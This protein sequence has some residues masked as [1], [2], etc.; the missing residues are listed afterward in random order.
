MDISNGIPYKIT[1]DGLVDTIVEIEIDTEF[2][3]EAIE[4]RI[5]DSIKKNFPRVRFHKYPMSGA[6]ADKHF[7]ADEVFRFF[8]DK[9][10]ISVNIVSKYPGWDNYMGFLKGAIQGLNSIEGELLKFKKARI[11]FVS[12]FVNVSIFDVWD[13]NPLVLNHIPPFQGREFNFSFDILDSKTH[14]KLAKAKVVLTDKLPIRDSKNTYSRIDVGL[15]S[16]SSDGS[17]DHTYKLLQV[18]HDNEKLAF[19]RLLSEEFVNSLHPQWKK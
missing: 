16:I 1:L 11:N 13:G 15:E 8:V 14:D 19:F 2:T 10:L 17:W 5:L 12:H 7:W 4:K 6:D 18:L 3:A 9:G